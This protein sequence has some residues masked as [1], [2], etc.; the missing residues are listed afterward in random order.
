MKLLEEEHKIYETFTGKKATTG[1]VQ[2]TPFD[3]FVRAIGTIKAREFS[4]GAD[5]QAKQ[6]IGARKVKP[7][8][9]T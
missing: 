5:F 4:K 6:C 3:Q 7:D 2:A 9:P 1:E 8:N